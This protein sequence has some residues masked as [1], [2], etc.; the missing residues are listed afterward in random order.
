LRN[1]A[2]HSMSGGRLPT[3]RQSGR[4]NSRCRWRCYSRW[5][6]SS[7]PPEGDTG[8]KRGSRRMSPP[9]TVKKRLWIS[10]STIGRSGT[11]AKRGQRIANS[12]TAESSR[13]T[14]I[15]RTRLESRQSS[16]GGSGDQRSCLPG[17]CLVASN[18]GYASSGPLNL[19]R[20]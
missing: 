7:L 18:A 12:V 8:M 10:R 17:E 4:K 6:A 5:V 20:W 9:K 14:M 11:T 2:T 16:H 15:H 13:M 1:V 3:T 19:I